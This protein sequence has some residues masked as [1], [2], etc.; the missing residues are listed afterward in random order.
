MT[1][2]Q[3]FERVRA[4]AN[5]VDVEI[6]DGEVAALLD[7]ARVAAHGSERWAAPITTYLVGLAV[8]NR[9]PTDRADELR[10]L[11]EALDPG[12]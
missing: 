4:E 12:A 11:L 6:T 9:D 10:R 3:W 7:L 8:A 5:I 1:V 2:A